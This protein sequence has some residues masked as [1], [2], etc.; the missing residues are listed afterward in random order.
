MPKLGKN[1]LK[2]LKVFH[3]VAAC[4]WIGGA[5]GL[6]VL[7]RYNPAAESGGML[8]G[9]N[10]AG[11]MIDIYVVVI[12]GAVGC[13]LTGLL[14]GIFTG[15]GFF[16]H[17][18]VTFKWIITVTAMLSGTFLLGEWEGKM[19][20]YSAGLGL[21]AFEDAGYLSVRLKHFAVGLVQLGMLVFAVVLSVFKPWKK[22]S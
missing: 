10:A 3:L 17:R 9:I 7:N 1:G 18:W 13:L 12:P 6:A 5:V 4:C 8:Y 16:K 19:V 20:E 21:G 22:K 14:Y 2:V 11:H 15:W